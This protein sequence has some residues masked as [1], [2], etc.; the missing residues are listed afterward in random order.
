MA[1]FEFLTPQQAWDARV[2]YRANY[3]R[4]NIAAYSGEHMELNAT[5]EKGM[6]WARKGG[7][8]KLHVPVGADIAA[9]S[10]NLLFG[11]EPSFTCYDEATEDN[12]S[13]QQHRLD[14]LVEKNNLHSK[15]NEAAET[16]AALG[17]VYLKLNWRT[18]ELDYPVITVVQADSAW[19][20]YLLGV[21]K[22]IHFFSVVKRDTKTD[23][24]IR[25]YEL[26]KPGE[27]EMR[28]FRGGA[29]QLGTEMPSSELAKYGFENI[30]KAPNGIED[31]LAV[32]IPN[33]RPNRIYRDTNMGRSDFDGLRGLM[34]SLDEVYSSWIRDVR[35][36]KA[37]TIVPAEYLKRPPQ[38]ML[39]GEAASVSWEFDAD[40]DT[41]VAIDMQDQSGNAPGITLQQFSIRSGDHAATC[42][43]LLRNIVSIAGY[44]PQTF[45]MDIN[46]MAQSGTALH[47]REKKSYDTCGKKQ[48][49]WK[50]P[51][52]KIMTALVHL[53]SALY[54]NA[55]SDA[56]DNV[57]L[58]FADSTSNDIS[59][60]AAAVQML[61]AA[62]AVSTEIKVEML[63]P[64]WTQKQIAEEVERVKTAERLGMMTAGVIS[65]E[66]M[67]AYYMGETPEQARA[68]IMAMNPQE[69]DEP[70]DG[71]EPTNTSGLVNNGDE[72][73]P[74][75][76]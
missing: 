68:A 76:E 50:A 39:T 44:A 40:I 71:S 43:E 17:D 57:K 72:P 32:H 18:D 37:R 69:S 65:K 22:G 61:N 74:N 16:C 41:F 53:D 9:V 10:S 45:G 11:E 19:P 1:E 66:E 38:E 54:P 2:D 6:F 35:L 14:E 13:K 75:A 48:T 42:S 58:R 25:V 34:D 59:T 26:Y 33:M 64:D 73:E 36:A 63:H 47:I 8:A 70:I 31:L 7:K 49:Y 27:I 56:D 3:Y 46:G 67:R 12:E 23:E 60:M 21:L 30:V 15:L 20:E 4:Q 62:N 29:E 24:V 5:S 28:M 55:G 52:E 51:L